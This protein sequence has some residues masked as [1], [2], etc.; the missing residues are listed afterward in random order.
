MAARDKAWDDFGKSEGW[1]KL[2][3][4]PQYL[5]TVSATDVT[6]LRPA[7]YSQI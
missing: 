2:R 3:A 7:A 4:E 5:N 6:F 1:N